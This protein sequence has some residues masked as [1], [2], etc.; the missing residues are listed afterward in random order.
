MAQGI[1]LLD[2]AL[3]LA[4]KEMTALEEKDYEKAMELA[5][6]RN[7]ITAMAWSVLESDGAG[8][9]RKRLIELTRMQE[10]L[11]AVA[12]EAEQIARTDLRRTRMEK[13][14]LQGYHRAVGMALQ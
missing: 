4:Q 5:E 13:Q 1:T 14:R 12:T 7:E 11:T 9:Y 6:K 10:A 8:A 3:H 2:Q